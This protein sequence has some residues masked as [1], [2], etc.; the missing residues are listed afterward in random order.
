MEL[1]IQLTDVGK[2]V[3]GLSA[4]KVQRYLINTPYRHHIL[5]GV[6]TSVLEPK[7]FLSSPAPRSRKCELRLRLGIVLQD[8]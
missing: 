5:Y 6:S 7:T 3:S 4:E 1:R 2:G 8:N